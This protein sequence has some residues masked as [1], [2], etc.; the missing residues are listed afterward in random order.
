MT[1]FTSPRN[2]KLQRPAII[3]RKTKKASPPPIEVIT[4]TPSPLRFH[5]VLLP[6]KISPTIRRPSVSGTVPS[7]ISPTS[8]VGPQIVSMYSDSIPEIRVRSI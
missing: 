6:L 5:D 7:S 1:A 4:T 3:T 2:P 8:C